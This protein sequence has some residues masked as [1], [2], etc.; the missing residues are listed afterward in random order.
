MLNLLIGNTDWPDTLAISKLHDMISATIAF[1]KAGENHKD[2]L[3]TVFVIMSTAVDPSSLNCLSM[4]QLLTFPIWLNIRRFWT[5]DDN[6]ASR[7]VHPMHAFSGVFPTVA[8]M[9]MFQT[10]Q[11]EIEKKHPLSDD[12]VQMEIVAAEF[13]SSHRALGLLTMSFPFF[14]FQTFLFCPIIK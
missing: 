2:I 13:R 3:N 11:D 8:E 14:R 9:K 10:N 12:Q 7:A 5:C 1:H 6:S 4:P